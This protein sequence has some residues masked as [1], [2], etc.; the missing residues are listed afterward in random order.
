RSPG[1]PRSRSTARRARRSRSSRKGPR[2]TGGRYR[3]G[4]PRSR[5]RPAR[6]SA[7]AARAQVPRRARRRGWARRRPRAAPRRGRRR[8]VRRRSTRARAR[9][10]DRSTSCS[11]GC[12]VT[13]AA[14]ADLALGALLVRLARGAPHGQR[15]LGVLVVEA[16]ALR[17]YAERGA[18]GIFGVGVRL[19][20]RH[21]DLPAREVFL[22][23]AAW[24]Q[25]GRAV[26]REGEPVDAPAV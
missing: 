13:N 16:P 15:P 7:R 22:V 3:T 24:E 26:A 1:R 11:F 6:R 2:R 4:R 19:E 14:P 9:A 5:P 17:R 25:A 8:K 21:P 10:R 20:R 23:A 12:L 18:R